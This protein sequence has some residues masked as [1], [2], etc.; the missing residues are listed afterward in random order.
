MPVIPELGEAKVV[1]AR[2]WSTLR[3]KLLKYTHLSW[4][5]DRNVN[6]CYP[7]LPPYG[8]DILSEK[9][10]GIRTGMF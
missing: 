2:S 1:G 10:L 8:D 3:K 9:R 6:H 7:F 5:T 4:L